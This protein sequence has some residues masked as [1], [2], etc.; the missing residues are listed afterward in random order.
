MYGD[1]VEAPTHRPAHPNR[2][3][4]FVSTLDLPAPATHPPAINHAAY[5][6][7]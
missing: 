2:L 3:R 4:N 1:A 7:A 6:S 5:F